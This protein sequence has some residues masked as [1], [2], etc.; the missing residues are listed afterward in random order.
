MPKKKVDKKTVTI[1]TC[2]SQRAGEE[3]PPKCACR[4][5]TDPAD[6]RRLVALDNVDWII[7]GKRTFRDK[8]CVVIEV[9]QKTP[10][11]ATIEKAHIERAYANDPK[12][13]SGAEERERIEEYGR[14]TL[15][16]WNAMVRL[17]PAAEFDEGDDHDF[18]IPVV[19]DIER[20]K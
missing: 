8:V 5:K 11:V 19:Y 15:A 1:H 4:R 18:G 20:K 13:P 12:D 3:M 6:A 2:F 7:I 9:S 16:S 14:L 17:V 10:R